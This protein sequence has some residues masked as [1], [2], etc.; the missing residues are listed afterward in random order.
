M[1]STRSTNIKKSFFQIWLRCNCL[2]SLFKFYSFNFQSKFTSLSLA[3]KTDK[4]TLTNRLDLQQR[5]RDIAEKNI[6][7]EIKQLKTGLEVSSCYLKTT[8]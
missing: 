8:A 1:Y 4:L 5:Q 6:E 3:F 2:F 7:E